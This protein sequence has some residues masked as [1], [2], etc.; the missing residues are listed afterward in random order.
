MSRH[1][2]GSDEFG[3]V[4]DVPLDGV[5][6]R[7]VVEVDG[8]G[9]ASGLPV[10]FG[11]GHA[12]DDRGRFLQGVEAFFDAPQVLADHGPAALADALTRRRPLAD[13]VV[14]DITNHWLER[15]R[16]GGWA[17]SCPGGQGDGVGV[18]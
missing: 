10:A 2:Q 3:G 11:V 12:G 8:V 18:C 14:D 6:H 1:L 5:E 9:E 13:L 4:R 17:G 7:V 15:I 16:P